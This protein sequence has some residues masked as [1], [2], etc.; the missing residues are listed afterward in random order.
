[1]YNNIVCKDCKVIAST[2]IYI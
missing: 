1:M 2:G